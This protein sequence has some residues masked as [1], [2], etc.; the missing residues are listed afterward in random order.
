MKLLHIFQIGNEISFKHHH[1]QK[2]TSLADKN[3]TAIPKIIS[4]ATE[5]FIK[6]PVF[7]TVLKIT[8]EAI[9]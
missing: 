9:V 2:Y 7:V 4:T 1:F 3:F 6:S 5:I 8:P